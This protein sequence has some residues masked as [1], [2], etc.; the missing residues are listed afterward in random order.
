MVT[1]D[2]LFTDRNVHRAFDV[3][4][5]ILAA[6]GGHP[7]D[8]EDAKQVGQSKHCSVRT[9]V[10]APGALDKQAEDEGH[11]EDGQSGDRHLAGPEGKQGI[12]GI[13]ILEEQFPAGNGDVQHPNQN[14][15]AG[16]AQDL[17][18]FVGDEVIVAFGLEDFAANLG[19][20]FLDGAQ[21]QTQPQKT[22]PNRMARTKT[23]VISAKEDWRTF[24]TKVPV[25]MN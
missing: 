4:S 9:G 25:V 20:P 17:V 23:I 22:G 10:L 13:V 12:V 21:R 15:I 6:G 5:A 11:A 3:A 18:Q 19:H 24:C 16:V 2:L 1:D 8:F 14:S 7:P